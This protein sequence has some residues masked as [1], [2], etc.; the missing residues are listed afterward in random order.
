[1]RL[2]TNRLSQGHPAATDARLGA[3]PVNLW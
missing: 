2:H 3:K 1:L